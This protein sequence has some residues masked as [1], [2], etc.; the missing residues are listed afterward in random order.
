MPAKTSHR[1][2]HGHARYRK[3][4]PNR[5]SEYICWQGTKKR[6]PPRDPRWDS[7]LN[8][9]S[10]MGKKPSPHRCY[11]LSR[12]DKSK[13]YGPGNAVWDKFRGSKP[14][15]YMWEGI[16]YTL[17]ELAWAAGKNPSS[18]LWRLSSGMTPEQAIA[19][20][21]PTRA[22]VTAFGEK[23]TLQEW[24]LDPRCNLSVSGIKH[25]LSRGMQGE[26]ALC[27]TPPVRTCIEAFGER[28]TISEWS[29]DPRCELSDGGIR[30]NLSLGKGGEEALQAQISRRHYIDAFGE[31]KWL[32]EWSKD[33]RCNLS[34]SGIRHRLDRGM[35]GEEAITCTESA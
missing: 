18:L 7:F 2:V 33:P 23:K 26:D 19:A 4:R 5:T 25:R 9:L 15:M 24:A 13:G 20:P 27:H 1:I 11:R 6:L 12:L 32:S 17:P 28:K 16:E 31:R 8:F 14:N 21:P 3:G 30:Y 34:V 10:D 35:R 29:R 22:Y